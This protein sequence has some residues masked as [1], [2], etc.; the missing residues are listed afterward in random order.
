MT[1]DSGQNWKQS[2]L[3]LQPREE[4]A[5]VA[6]SADGKTGLV[7]GYRGSV[8][9]DNGQWENLE[10][11]ELGPAAR[12]AVTAVAL[13]ADGKTGLVAG[14]RG[15]VFVTTDSG[16]NL[17]SVELGPAGHRGGYRGGAQRGR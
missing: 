13:S 15:L 9:H 16:E 10:A 3:D 8:F 4:V 1:T 2:N 7:A 6:L 17:E 12:R 11:V 14:D 5:A